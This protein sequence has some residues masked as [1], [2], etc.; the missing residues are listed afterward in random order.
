MPQATQ[1][2]LRA[3]FAGIGRILSVTDKVR[4]R[5]ASTE[6][7]AAAPAAGTTTPESTA[8][9]TAAPEAA[10][11]TAAPETMAPDTATPEA[12]APEAEVV[13]TTEAEAEAPAEAVEE[14]P[15]AEAAAPEAEVKV[16]A[17]EEPE[18]PAAE[19]AAKAGTA[20]EDLPL[21]NYGELTIASVR[22][23]LRN[24]SVEQ[25]N[26]LVAYEKAN[27]AREDFISMFE[28][29]IAKVESGK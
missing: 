25:L 4:N 18:A 11:E 27:A 1:S 8:P 29:R 7:P 22:A 9:E 13:E 21:P 24:L 28:R 15:E 20:A 17:V 19:E 2:P 12:E 26:T 5:S 16:E 10:A 3:V 6:A 14:A 23:R